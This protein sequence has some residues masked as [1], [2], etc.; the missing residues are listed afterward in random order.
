MRQPVLAL[1]LPF[2]LLPSCIST[3]D[4]WAAKHFTYTI[5][6]CNQTTL[7]SSTERHVS[8]KLERCGKDMICRVKLLKMLPRPLR[9]CYR[10]PKLPPKNRAACL[11]KARRIPYIQVDN[12]AGRS[13]ATVTAGKI[14]ITQRL[15]TYCNASR[16][17]TLRLTRRNRTLILTERFKARFVTKCVCPFDIKATVSG[18]DKGTYTL[19]VVFDNRYAR[20]KEELHSVEVKVE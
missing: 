15:I 1:F 6:G 18:L 8:S 4:A 14:T 16:R 20:K 17:L 7:P 5:L 2:L 12:R 19:K 10:N 13:K 11:E 3:S 9:I